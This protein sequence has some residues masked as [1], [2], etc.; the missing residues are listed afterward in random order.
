MLH[1]K[2]IPFQEY[3][4]STEKNRY[5]YLFKKDDAIRDDNIRDENE[6]NIEY[7]NDFTNCTNILDRDST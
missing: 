5:E 3:E 2:Y 6:G 4:T 7:G 1:R